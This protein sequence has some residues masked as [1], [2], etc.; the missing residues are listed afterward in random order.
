MGG[1]AETRRV[2]ITLVYDFLLPFHCISVL[3]FFSR[4][5]KMETGPEL[6]E[7]PLERYKH[8]QKTTYE[9]PQWSPEEIVGAYDWHE[10]VPFETLLLYRMGDV[11]FPLFDSTKELRALDFGCGPGRMVLRMAKLFRQVD[12][13]DISARLVEFAKAKCPDSEFFVTNGDDLG[14]APENAYDFI[15][16]TIAL[17]HIAVHDIRAK[18]FRAMERCLRPGGQI[19]LQFCFNHLF[20]M[21]KV[22]RKHFDGRLLWLGPETDHARWTENRTDATVTNGCCDVGIGKDDLPLI[23]QEFS[24]LFD[25][26]EFWFYDFAHHRPV[27]PGQYPDY[28]SLGD[29]RYWATHYLIIHATKKA[30]A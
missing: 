15:F 9:Q 4:W 19:S 7:A 12:G 16:S 30:S 28:A 14:G 23:K 18:I 6:T 24:E 25:D 13:A 1:R 20:P 11:R 8:M 5:N 17:Q 2:P 29:S 21:S 10:T 3:P 26:V 27:G 22:M